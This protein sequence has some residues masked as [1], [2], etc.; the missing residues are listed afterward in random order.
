[1]QTEMKSYYSARAS[2]YDAVITAAERKNDIEFLSRFYA[3]SLH[4]SSANTHKAR[5]SFTFWSIPVT[6]EFSYAKPE[7]RA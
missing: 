3:F 2:Y 7:K 5:F 6:R 1:M 4:I